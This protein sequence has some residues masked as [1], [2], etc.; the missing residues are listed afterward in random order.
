[1]AAS[2][3]HEAWADSIVRGPSESQAQKS[4]LV[5]LPAWRFYCL[6]DE[7]P[8]HLVPARLVADASAAVFD[9]LGLNPDCRFSRDGLL[10]PEVAPHLH[11]L[12]SLAWEGT[13]AW[14]K[15]PGSRAWQPFWLGPELAEQITATCGTEPSPSSLSP[16]LRDV[17]VRAGILV[18]ANYLSRRGREW[19]A[20]TSRCAWRFREKGYA[21]MAGLIH[22]FHLGAL[23]RYYRCL[24]RTGKLPLGDGQSP[25]RYVAHNESV[26]R[27][28][29]HQLTA[30]VSA[31]TGEAVKPSYVYLA[32]YQSG[33][34][35]D[36]HTDREQ[37]EFSISLCVDYSPEPARE[38]PWPLHLDTHEGTAT[39][40][41]AIGDGLLYRGTQLPHYRDPLP[42][43]N[44]S[45]S[46]FFHYVR[47]SFTGELD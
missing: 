23:R 24:I 12:Q 38:T 10:P 18:P 25:R 46:L 1:M 35:L 8:T 34:R 43:G 33:A 21:P 37:C 44:T 14:L 26:A 20:A 4:A 28:F 16:H 27:F 6:L 9:D 19:L 3:N 13:I 5:R 22:P 30:T 32:S 42:E 31:I 47:E 15:D 29:H 2:V 11:L 39:V 40:F 41:Q 7:Q 17:L 36:K 45:T